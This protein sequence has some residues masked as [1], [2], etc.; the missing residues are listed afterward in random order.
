MT[1]E[2][3]RG[4]NIESEYMQLL[5]L[6]SAVIE[7]LVGWD[8]DDDQRSFAIDAENLTRK[9]SYHGL[10]TL[11]LARRTVLPDMFPFG[12]VGFIDFTSINVL[13]R[14]MLETY[15]TF[16]YIYIEPKDDPSLREFRRLS[17]MLSSL[18][19]RQKY[20]V[21]TP[22]GTQQL[23][24]DRAIIEKARVELQANSVF[25]NKLDTGKQEELLKKGT[26]AGKHPPFQPWLEIAKR[27][28]LQPEYA[29]TVYS[30]LSIHAHSGYISALQVEQAKTDE[31][32][33]KLMKGTLTV[34]VVTI[35]KMIFSYC[36]L[37]PKAGEAL[38]EMPEA[39]RL[40]EIYIGAS[41]RL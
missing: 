17:I 39:A 30:F 35:A 34:G 5:R 6:L 14:A 31:E 16:C 23:A 26:I 24:K 29:Q 8:I 38:K 27:T 33:Y 15:L 3:K 22:E 10:S 1:T 41:R 20:P 37:F 4:V 18:L 12:V 7:S 36:E 2:S 40:A 19:Q 28:G 32:R 13:V 21:R 25:L 11:Y 9:F